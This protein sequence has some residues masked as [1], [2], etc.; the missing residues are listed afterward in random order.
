MITAQFLAEKLTGAED[1]SGWRYHHEVKVKNDRLKG[2]IS[3]KM[4]PLYKDSLA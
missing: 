1:I 3:P 2:W 4:N